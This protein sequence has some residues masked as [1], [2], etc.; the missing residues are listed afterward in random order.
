M[1]ITNYSL[2][3]KDVMEDKHSLDILKLLTK[4]GEAKAGLSTYYT[5]LRHSGK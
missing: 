5:S 2:Q 1:I 4:R 3:K